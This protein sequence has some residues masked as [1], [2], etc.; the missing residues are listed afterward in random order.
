MNKFTKAGITALAGSLAAFS[1]QAVEMSAAG[2]AK[3]T[4][5]NGHQT[6]PT[7][8]PYGMNT[9]ISFTG[10][11]E[12]NGY[13]T[14]L[15]VTNSDSNAGLSSASLSVDLGDM[16]KLTF[17][18]AVGAGGISTIDDKTPSANEEVWDG[19]DAVAT[20]ANGLV[21][22]GN[23][24]VLVYANSY[25]AWNLSTQV[26][27]GASSIGS[28]DSRGSGVGVSGT[29]WDFAL[30][31]DGLMENLSAGF[32]YGK[33]A[34]GSQSDANTDTDEHMVVFAN[35]SMGM[36]TVGWTRAEID[37]GAT[38]A[39]GEAAVGVGISANINDNL[40]VSYGEREIDYLKSAAADVT[41][42]ISGF[43]VAYTMGSAKITFQENETTNNGGTVGNSDENTE[44]ALSLSF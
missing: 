7:G 25:G 15:L 40:S 30:T 8:N 4:Y 5:N 39:T 33:I 32:G 3:L 22:G 43:A 34:N 31:T 23:S 21:G 24:G 19:L 20:T 13:T 6:E 10:S 1:A 37:K 26:S 38:G 16:G 27:K 42:D 41:E 14:S 28:D 18:Q 36:V 2:S 35:Y 9:S 44:I 11:G 12:V 29:S 17:D